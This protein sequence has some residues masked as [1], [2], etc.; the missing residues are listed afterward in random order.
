MTKNY[1]KLILYKITIILQ[2]SF[3]TDHLHIEVCSMDTNKRL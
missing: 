2:L 1:K 3:S